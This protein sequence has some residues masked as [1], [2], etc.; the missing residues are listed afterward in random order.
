[1]ARKRRAFSTL[2]PWIVGSVCLVVLFWI[3]SIVVGFVWYPTVGGGLAAQPNKSG[4][5]DKSVGILQLICGGL[6]FV[7]TQVYS[8]Q[9]E[10]R[11]VISSDLA[12]T[13]AIW[14]KICQGNSNRGASI[15]SSC[16]S[17]HGQ[18]GIGTAD[19]IPSLAGLP[20]EVIY[21]ELIDY[22]TGKRNY[23]IMNAVAAGLSDQDIAD[24]A[25]YYSR[26]LG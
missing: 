10:P 7:N 13:D 6:G 16:M 26:R 14:E 18:Q 9:P 3:V 23:V 2:S 11:A 5:A 4:I 17:C 1:M 8:A 19:Y 22:Q 12:W 20:P 24:V 15:S 21:K 25:G